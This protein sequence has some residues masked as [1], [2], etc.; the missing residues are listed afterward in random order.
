MSNLVPV[1]DVRIGDV[2]HRKN[3]DLFTVAR[4]STPFWETVAFHD[5]DG[6][7]IHYSETSSV[8]V[9]GADEFAEHVL[10]VAL[11]ELDPESPA[12]SNA[13]HRDAAQFLL[14]ALKAAKIAVVELPEPCAKDDDGQV[15]FGDWDIRADCS[16]SLAYRMVT[17]DFGLGSEVKQ[18]MP[19]ARAEWWARHLL[20]AAAEVSK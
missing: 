12:V 8:G 6:D 11:A 19:P 9:A 14:N 1:N 13:A 5:S 10:A 3:G 16:G 20:A 2:I 4:V 17:T 15:F 18:S 7:E